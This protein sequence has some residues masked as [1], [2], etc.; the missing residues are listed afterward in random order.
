MDLVVI[1][2]DWLMEI[3]FRSKYRTVTWTS[4]GVS[5]VNSR[6]PIPT[7]STQFD[8]GVVYGRRLTR[9]RD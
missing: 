7:T 6:K 1:L 2:I 3:C 8:D 5:L 4:E 9:R